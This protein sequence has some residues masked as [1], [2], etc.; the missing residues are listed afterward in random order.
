M[1]RFGKHS[2][3]SKLSSA[4]ECSG[5]VYSF[6][7]GHLAVHGLSYYRPFFWLFESFFLY[8]SCQNG[9]VVCTVP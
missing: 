1:S 3:I 4:K 6:C 8:C 2:L 5:Y 9:C 7:D